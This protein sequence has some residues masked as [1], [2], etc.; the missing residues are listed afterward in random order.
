MPSTEF[1]SVSFTTEEFKRLLKF[2]SIPIVIHDTETVLH[3]NP[4]VVSTLGAR[5][6]DDLIGRKIMDFI[7][8][9]FREVAKTR[10]LS[11]F[12]LKEP[13]PPLEE[14]ILDYNGHTLRVMI[15]NVPV[16]FGGK[17]AVLAIFT[18]VHG[19]LP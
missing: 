15:E 18:N 5:S 19:S 2:T 9:E 10:M 6:M 1:N 17:T 12:E 11:A 3:V 13:N 8:S 7:A 14:N 4:A 16:C